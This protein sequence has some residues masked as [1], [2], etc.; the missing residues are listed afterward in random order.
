MLNRRKFIKNTAIT[1]GVILSADLLA[2]SDKAGHITPQSKDNFPVKPFI[3][4]V[5]SGDPL[6]SQII[7]WT[8]V[9]PEKEEAIMVKWFVANDNKFTKI[10]QSGEVTTDSNVDYTV[11]VDVQNLLPSATY[12]YQFSLNN[13]LS[14]VGRT[15]TTPADSYEDIQ[16]AVVS[17]SDYAAGYYNALARI[18][19][20]KA[21]H[22]VVHL[23]DYIYEGTARSF[24]P[25]HNLPE[26][27]FES[28]HFNR[29]RAWWL[30]YYRR[31][32]SINRLDPDLQAAHL[33]HP[34]IT[35]WDDHEI[36]NNAW[37]GGADGH[38]PERD[39]EWE[40]RKSAAMQ[41][42]AEWMP[43]R[44]N[45]TRIYRSIRYG[46]MAEL[47]LL[48]TRLEGRDQ[49][50][51]DAESQSLYAADRTIL[52]K[53]QKQWLFQTLEASPCLWKLMAN[54]VV[55]SEFNVKWLAFGGLFLDKVQQLQHT[56]LDYWE[57]Y[58]T[59]RDEIIQ[60]IIKH[61]LNNI[62]ILSASMHCALAFDVTARA[63]RYSRTGEAATYDAATGKGSVAVEFAATSITSDNFDEKLGK[64]YASTFQSLVNK[65]L[66]PPLNY[67]PNP[68]LKFADLQRHGYYVLHL[69]TEQ[70][71]ADFYFVDDINVNSRKETLA[72]AWH[73][74]TGMNRLEQSR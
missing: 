25:K 3:H 26:D 58:P 52:G 9:S 33:A 1:T 29:T 54:Q 13:V 39:G 17:C 45:A 71:R 40:L 62:I 30:H 68:H 12:Y 31:R 16:L 51:Y 21:L 27:N 6:S 34:F 69:S 7:I 73:T 37:R 49:Q 14:P 5:A 46:K 8:R 72:A 35:I 74:K 43:I 57:G 56:L 15:R 19:D 22:A 42:Y 70:A 63:T 60:H 50:I 28:I 20:R 11:K 55:F 4:G 59:E 36:A 18:A 48:D 53:D 38:D 61:K 24:D 67:N 2:A 44:G 47:V 41:A 66:P 64:F 65:K 10:F 32:Y 23:G